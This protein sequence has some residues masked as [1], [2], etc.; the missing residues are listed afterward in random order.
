MVLVSDIVRV[1]VWLP[2]SVPWR[3]RCRLRDNAYQLHNSATNADD[4]A[5][6]TMCWH[7]YLLVD[8]GA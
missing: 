8:S 6:W 5:A 4:G 7:L 1:F 3:K 2:L